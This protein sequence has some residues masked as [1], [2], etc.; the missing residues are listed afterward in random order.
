MVS[1]ARESG[2]KTPYVAVAEKT[3]PF[4]T[5][6]GLLLV[7]LFV[8]VIFHLFPRLNTEGARFEMQP[9]ASTS[10]SSINER[11][12][13][14]AKMPR[15]IQQAMEQILEARNGSRATFVQIGANDGEMFDPLYPHLKEHKSQWIGLQVEPQPELYSRVAVLHADA[16]PD[17]AFYHGAL[18][19]ASICING[20]VSFCETKTPGTGDWRTQGQLNSINQK[21]CHSQTMHYQRRPCQTSF[22][23]LLQ[24]HASRAFL[25]H[26][27]DNDDDAKSQHPFNIDLLQIDVE[28]KDYDLLLLINWA[29]LRPQCIHY[30]HFHLRD[31]E[32]L[33]Q[34]LMNM[35]GYTT[36]KTA[37]DT[38]ACWVNVSSTA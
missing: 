1:I 37:M 32:P 13:P 27:Q 16:T 18:A 4:R 35:H 19:P 36:V 17:W 24:N 7:I 28:G 38:L 20:T 22:D 10:T 15:S 30:E 6:K 5:C 11:L 29:T 8:S 2:Q 3:Y 31:K 21:M 23:A 9:A 33:A 12:R 14:F 34:E 25:Q 26:A